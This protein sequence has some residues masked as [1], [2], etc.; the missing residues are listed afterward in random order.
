MSESLHG[1]VLDA[2]HRD[3]DA[4]A[5]AWKGDSWRYERLAR[6]VRALAGSWYAAGLRRGDPIALVQ[7][8]GPGAVASLYAA[9]WLGCP[10][11]PI[12]PSWPA[13]RV[14][15]AIETLDARGWVCPPR[16]R[17]TLAQALPDWTPPALWL[18]PEADPG[19]S[20]PEPAAGGHQAAYALFTSGSTGRPKGV[21]H[22]HASAL[23]FVR[24]AVAETHL[25]S[26]DRVGGHASLAFDLST[27][28]VYGAAASG[29]ALCP[30]PESICYRGALLATFIRESRLT[31]FY[32][33][34]SAWPG[35]L[36]ALGPQG[37]LDLQTVLFAGEVFP[38]E[39]LRRLRRAAPDARL[40]NLYGP[41]ETNVVTWHEVGD[42]DLKEATPYPVIGRPCP[43]VTC[44]VVDARGSDAPE[45][46][47]LVQGPTMMI[48]YLGESPH[49]GAYETGDRVRRTPEG[50]LRFCGRRD[51]QIKL[52]G[53]RIELA[54]VEAACA[55]A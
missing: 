2:A 18:S 8:R 37:T 53:H 47:L 6:E 55:S 4:E 11:A 23:A 3:P 19:A 41:T 21:L 32:A 12:D 27:F 17:D 38:L 46:Q 42:D 43:G 50:L 36:D 30:V 28:D 49:A 16:L 54:E 24:W 15:R 45:G 40:L 48:G 1:L 29:A 5:I 31:T 9:S 22:S 44:R 35:V 13:K 26:S 20:A 39:Q 7:P 51:R 25:A 52:R 14:A 33:V 10:F 34:P